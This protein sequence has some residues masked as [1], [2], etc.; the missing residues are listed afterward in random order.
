[1]RLLQILIQS[2]FELV[3]SEQSRFKRNLPTRA[4]PFVGVKK[5]WLVG[6]LGQWGACKTQ[7]TP[8]NRACRSAALSVQQALKHMRM[9]WLFLINQKAYLLTNAVVLFCI[10]IYIYLHL[11][12]YLTITERTSQ[13]GANS[14]PWSLC[15]CS[16][17]Q[18]LLGSNIPAAILAWLPPSCVPQ[19]RISL[20]WIA[21]SG[22]GIYQLYLLVTNR[23]NKGVLEEKSS[24]FSTIHDN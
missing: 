11:L 12:K 22:C 18:P 15:L 19:P 4:S 10:Y 14:P 9:R 23:C 8:L 20:I 5:P 2:I 17:L 21:S 6:G 16:T 3:K 1:M 24:V 13:H 7:P